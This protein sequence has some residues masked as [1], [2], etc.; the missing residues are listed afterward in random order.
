MKN[1][2]KSQ[3]IYFFQQKN[4]KI[5]KT[6]FFNQSPP[7]QPISESRGGGSPERDG[8]VRVVVVA[9]GEN[10]MKF[11]LESLTRF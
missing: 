2:D 9:A 6:V 10:K 8:G 5:L 1:V 3:K 11:L 4:L 7:V